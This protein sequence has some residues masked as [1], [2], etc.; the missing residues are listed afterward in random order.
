MALDPN[1]LGQIE[2][3]SLTK[4]EI[5]K[6]SAKLTSLLNEALGVT[7]AADEAELLIRVTDGE[8]ENLSEVL[9]LGDDPILKNYVS[10]KLE[11]I[12]MAP[13][14]LEATEQSLR[15]SGALDD[16]QRSGE[17]VLSTRLN[18]LRDHLDAGTVPSVPTTAPQTGKTIKKAPTPSAK[19]RDVASFAKKLFPGLAAEGTLVDKPSKKA[20]VQ[21][22]MHLSGQ[23]VQ[24]PAE[25]KK[26]SE[27][28]K[29]IDEVLGVAKRGAASKGPKARADDLLQTILKGAQQEAGGAAT[30]ARSARLM[31]LPLSE[32]LATAGAAAEAVAPAAA[33]APAVAK[34]GGLL[35]K[36]AGKG[37]TA[38]KVAGGFFLLD[39]LLAANRLKNSAVTASHSQH[40]IEAATQATRAS[41]PALLQRF[42]LNQRSQ[43]ADAQMLRANPELAMMQGAGPPLPQNVTF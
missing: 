1:L 28:R 25:I 2:A 17:A 16:W 43:M 34:P 9:G 32:A 7:I 26:S 14:E 4:G 33:A 23:G 11:K 22:L 10:A 36:L 39:A 18:K 21:E 19:R 37:L 6:L 8:I 40:N 38:G 12:K 13:K 20:L 29:R 31:G 30:T 24:F 35:S 3:P 41:T 15:L 27:F 5:K 42:L